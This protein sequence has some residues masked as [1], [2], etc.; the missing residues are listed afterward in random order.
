MKRID[1]MLLD[2]LLRGQF[3]R[4][5]LI[6]GCD[7]LSLLNKIVPKFCN[8]VFFCESV[9]GEF[10]DNSRAVYDYLLESRS[11]KPY[12]YIIAVTDKKAN[13]HLKKRNTIIVGRIVGIWYFLFSKYCFYSYSFYKI[14]PAKK[15]IVIN[16]WHGTPLKAIGAIS[17]DAINAGE[18]SNNFTYLLSA[19]PLFHEVFETAFECSKEKILCCGHTRTDVFF[20]MGL[21]KTILGL[22][23]F[24][25]TVI[26]MPTFRTSIDGR[27]ND[28]GKNYDYKKSETL[29]PLYNTFQ[30]LERLNEWL[31]Q[32]NMLLIIK[33]HSISPCS[34]FNFSN[35]RLYKDA[36]LNKKKV[37]LYALIRETDALITDYSSVYF[38]Y[39]LLNRPIGFIIDDIN[40][41]SEKR[42]FVLNPVLEYMPGMH[43]ENQS[44]FISFLGTII[45]E[46]DIHETQRKKVNHLCNYY[47]DG[48]NAKRLVDIIGL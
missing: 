38:D 45:N 16:Q 19:A 39:L 17:K 41:Y 21:E 22:D 37:S 35:I 33:I 14:K 20:R 3:T 31:V 24:S 44:D 47:R 9:P 43:I 36:D 25:K 46:T 2:H 27:H 18:K 32:K 30:E 10:H 11:E 40:L 4:K 42:G 5:I 6:I 8:Q 29:L 28:L 23:A 34:N 13:Q 26:W 7:I 48:N 15:Q 12:R 1:K